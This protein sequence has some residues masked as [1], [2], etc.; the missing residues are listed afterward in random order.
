MNSPELDISQSLAQAQA[1]SS[2]IATVNEIALA[3]NHSL[4]LD[5]ILQT[6]GKQAKWLLDFDHLS[7]YLCRGECPQLVTLFGLEYVM[8]PV[9]IAPTS[10]IALALRSG[11]PQLLR[12]HSDIFLSDFHSV[13][14]IPLENQKEILG[15]INF[16]TTHDINY[17][18]DDVRISYLLALQVAAAMRNAERF[19]E[20]NRVNSLLEQEKQKSDQLLLNILPQ[21]IAYELKQ[22]GRVKPV[23]YESA[24]VLFTDI[25][26]FSVL[27][28]QMSAEELV[29]ELDECFS[30]F[31]RIAEKYNLEKLKTIGDSYMC[32]GGIPTPNQTH[33]ID[34]VLSALEIQMLMRLRNAQ[35][36]KHNLPCWELRVGI[37][38]G[39]LLAGVIGQKKFTYDIWGDTVNTSSRIETCGI[40]GQVNISQATRDLVQ[41]FFEFEYR[42]KVAAKNKGE[43]DMYLV[44]R[45]KPE[46]SIDPR[47]FLPNDDFIDRYLAISSRATVPLFC[48]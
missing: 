21:T 48:A 29:A 35:R 43:I 46:L 28:Q 40:P 31:D 26:D 5:E 38:S 8:D 44:N 20:L 36:A 27:S 30:Y 13:I 45:I 16:A 11:Q 32:A 18:I 4:N 41:N 1:L 42:G 15:T 23:Y 19:E 24:S 47:G 22:S 33:A 17:T 14:I 37:H 34:A 3:L 25:K 7:V 9:T 10:A 2:R 6:L 12:E 39:P